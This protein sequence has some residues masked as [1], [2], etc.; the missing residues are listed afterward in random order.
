[1]LKS[2]LLNK[3]NIMHFS[4]LESTNTY[5]KELAENGEK[6]GTVVIADTQSNG[7]GRM[8]RSFLSRNGGLYMSILLRPYEDLS[9]FSPNCITNITPL[10]AVAVCEAIEKITDK[11]LRIK[12]VNDLFYN[13]KKVCGILAEA[14]YTNNGKIDY[15]VLGIG[16]NIVGNFDNTELSDI[17]TALY[18]ILNQ[19]ELDE[20]KKRLVDEILH[21][22]V[23]LYENQLAN[24]D[25]FDNYKNRLFIIGKEIEVLQ[26]DTVKT[27]TVI[28]LNKDF[29]LLVRYTDGNTTSLNSGEVRLRVKNV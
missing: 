16:I 3:L 27:A 25:F 17:A 13:G 26:G 20:L 22:L 5:L 1:M 11:I 29:T 28:D 12:W 18:P 7:K 23:I 2:N 8:G 19:N 15:I 6:S 10:C 21:K 4:S 9:E 14:S 24:S